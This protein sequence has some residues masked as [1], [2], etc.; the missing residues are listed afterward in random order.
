[1]DEM[2]SR[3]GGPKRSLIANLVAVAALVAVGLLAV[4]ALSNRA[5]PSERPEVG[6]LLPAFA[7]A[8]L[9]GGR[10]TDADLR[11]KPAFLN[12]WATWC[13]PC[14]R[15]MS[16]IQEIHDQYGGEIDV[17]LINFGESPA[18]V[19]SFL[20]ENSLSMPVALDEDMQLMAR[21][22]LPYLPTSIFIDRDGHVCKIHQVYMEKD[23]MVAAV[24]LARRG[25]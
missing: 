4:N 18:M 11:G 10:V 9:E 12:F 6:R 5:A 3:P 17:L 8:R 13:P 21:W 20:E 16:D 25:C 1:M 2:E 7:L 14:K 15:E 23:E 24:E 22:Q 19:R